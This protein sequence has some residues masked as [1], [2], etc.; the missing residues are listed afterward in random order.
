MMGA[1]TDAHFVVRVKPIL[2]GDVGLHRLDLQLA[3]P[4]PENPRFD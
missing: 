2:E 1:G 4:G 3:G